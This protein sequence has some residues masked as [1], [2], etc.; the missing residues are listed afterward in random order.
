MSTALL[1]NKALDLTTLSL[2]AALQLLSLLSLSF[3]LHLR[4]RSC[5]SADPLRKFNSLWTVRLLLVALVSLWSLSELL[6][7]SF[8]R[9]PYL[10]A[11]FAYAPLFS[12]S[13]QTTFCKAH[14]VLSLGFF[15]PAFLVT[16]LFL[17]NASINLHA[18]APNLWAISFVLVSCLPVLLLQVFSA[19]LTIPFVPSA[20]LREVF[21]LSR[22]RL[23]HHESI[24]CTYSPI[25]ALVFGAFA[26]GFL[27]YF[28]FSC[29]RVVSVVINKWLRVRI[30]LL[31][32]AISLSL[33]TQV[34]FLGFTAF[35]RL[36]GVAHSV[37]VLTVFLCTLCSAVA[38]L[39]ILVV[40][41][42]ADALVAGEELYSVWVPTTGSGS[43]GTP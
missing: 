21:V 1:L 43:R 27:F 35:W 34:L 18:R 12:P 22:D 9:D 16:I 11:F 6:R 13:Q 31:A 2:V 15:E 33:V 42:I 5:C 8:F 26:V 40:I 3:I 25:T 20:L 14:V 4:F 38:G 17:V 23:G 30:Y 32:F 36:E 19:F 29:Y 41:P 10:S 37:A 28:S 7:L 24:I 39:G